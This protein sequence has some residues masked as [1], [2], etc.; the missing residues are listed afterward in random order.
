[1]F[2]N[3]TVKQAEVAAYFKRFDE[4]EK[5]YLD[6]DRRDLAVGLRKKLGDWFRVVQL[7]KT[8]S[9]GDDQQLEEAWNAIGDYYADRQKW[10]VT[11]ASHAGMVV[12]SSRWIVA[13]R[14]QAVTYYLQG[15]NQERLAE[16]YYM[17]E[18]YAGLKKMM[19]SLPENHKL[20]PDIAGMF[21]T[22]GMCSEA[23][24]AYTKVKSPC[25]F[26]N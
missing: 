26:Q 15:R 10:Q 4:A 24:E 22:V 8:G 9:G 6:M 21:V 5:L 2:Q 13:C 25:L 18:N 7:L 3:E 14:H 17:L 23:V 12:I 19:E 16:C 20:L 1:M 11:N